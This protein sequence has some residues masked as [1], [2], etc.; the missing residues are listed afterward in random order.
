MTIVN[1]SNGTW[2]QKSL[3]GNEYALAV[4]TSVVTVG[5]YQNNGAQYDLAGNFVST[6]S[7]A[8]T[9][10]NI[11]WLD[12]TTDGT[13]NYTV[14]FFNG[15]VYRT[16]SNFNNPQV[17]FNAAG[18][19]NTD[20]GISYDGANNS[21]WVADRYGAQAGYV[22]DYSMSGAI[23]SEFST[24]IQ[25]NGDLAY[26]PNDGT[27]WMGTAADCG[28]NGNCLYQYSTGGTL[29]DSLVLT[30]NHDNII[31]GEFAETPSVVTPEPGTFVLLGTALA[32]LMGFARRRRS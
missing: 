24:G 31:G 22:I 27:L 29:L 6:L 11:Q 9:L 2:Y 30:G 7:N 18:S 14:D 12:G 5:A 25:Y 26:D 4:T 20:I 8:N 3:Q 15:N 10:P 19:S 13:Y 1:T 16:D 28:G 32:G 21:L 23:L 17:L